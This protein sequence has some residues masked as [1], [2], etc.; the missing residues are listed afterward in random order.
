MPR[1]VARG[2]VHGGGD[3]ADDVDLSADP[4]QHREL[5][6]ILRRVHRPLLEES[7]VR[8][9]GAGG[10]WGGA[11]AGSRPADDR[12]N[13]ES[14]GLCAPWRRSA[15]RDR[16]AAPPFTSG[17]Q[18][19]TVVRCEGSQDH[20]HKRAPVGPVTLTSQDEMA[21]W[22]AELEPRE[23]WTLRGFARSATGTVRASTPLS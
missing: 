7:C 10:C 9:G 2:G 5:A 19:M 15:D 16:L 17:G 1:R 23:I 22:R 8:A 11:G 3:V 18:S 13:R 4:E 12:T 21:D 6:G 20:R 14:W